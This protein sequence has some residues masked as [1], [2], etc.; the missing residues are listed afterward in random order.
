M[1]VQLLKEVAPVQLAVVSEGFQQPADLLD[2]HHV[3]VVFEQARP[4]IHPVERSLV[5]LV[6]RIQ[7]AK[8]YSSSH[9][10]A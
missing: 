6:I 2:V 7:P 5:R 4:E 3:N 10:L 1:R 9:V 8:G